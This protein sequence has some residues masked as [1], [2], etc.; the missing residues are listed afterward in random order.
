MWQSPTG[1]RNDRETVRHV[2]T[3]SKIIK[4]DTSNKGHAKTIHLVRNKTSIADVVS[5][6]EAR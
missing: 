5:N 2:C 6:F 4:T 1:Q 3:N